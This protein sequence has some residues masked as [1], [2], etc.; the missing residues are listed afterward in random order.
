MSNLTPVAKST[1]NVLVLASLA[2][3]AVSSTSAFAAV[4]LNDG[5]QIN[6]IEASCGSAQSKTEDADKAKEAKC[7]EAKCGADNKDAAAKSAEGKCGEA[8]CG[9]DKKD[10]EKSDAKTKEGKCGAG[11]CG[12]A[13]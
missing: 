3:L 9:G 11:K 10:A 8:K 13:I 5:Y 7:G 6:T 2:T 4:P 12:S 1:L